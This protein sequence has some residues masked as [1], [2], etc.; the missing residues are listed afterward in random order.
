VD[1]PLFGNGRV[2]G[3]ALAEGSRTRQVTADFVV[4]AV[5][6][7][8]TF[9]AKA[10]FPEPDRWA[11]GFALR[12][13]YSLAAPL[14]EFFQVHLPLRVPVSG[15]NIAGYGWVFPVNASLANIGVGFFPST[16]EDFSL[17]LRELF[18]QFI[19][20]LRQK[21]ARFSRMT[22]TGRLRGGPLP[23]GMDPSHCHHRGMLL[24]GDA[25]G[26]VDPFTG[27]GI[28]AALESGKMAA[29][30]LD[31]AL[32]KTRR[33]DADL[34]EYSRLLEERFRERFHAGR[35]FVKTYSFLWNVIEK[36]FHMDNPLF[37][38]LRK[39]AI[40][41][42]PNETGWLNAALRENAALVDALGLKEEFQHVAERFNTVLAAQNPLFPK[43]A[44]AML[45][46]RGAFLRL[47]LLFLCGRC[48]PADR[49]AA[50]VEAAVAVELCN[51]AMEVHD[52]VFDQDLRTARR[53]Q[54]FSSS[55]V[56]WANMFGVMAGNYLLVEAYRIFAGM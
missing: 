49:I 9:R 42:G 12:G 27:E 15:R 31:A 8:S 5:G 30:V 25:A 36:T 46:R 17:N 50:K 51:L 14:P 35:R 40:D 4:A 22:L 45:D 28:N 18:D 37:D 39:A 13:Y 32:N 47:A 1:G 44:R 53:P 34:A 38:G 19:E 55:E 26:L 21:D 7:S 54:S 48:G 41:Y 56:N 24:A 10:G 3:L 11:T 6:G 16:S 33:I 23:C 29:E 52:A 2:C 20:D 43:I